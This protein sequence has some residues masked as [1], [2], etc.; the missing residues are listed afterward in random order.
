MPF[1]SIVAG[2]DA[3]NLRAS[4]SAL[5]AYLLVTNKVIVWQAEAN[6]AKSD[7]NWGTLAWTTTASGAYTDCRA[8]M[9]VFISS[10]TDLTNPIVQ[11]RLR[12]TPT[13]TH[14]AIGES[15]QNVT[16]GD[17]ITV[18]DNFPLIEKKSRIESGSR[19]KDYDL[20]YKAPPVRISDIKP[21]YADLSG[22]ST[23]TWSLAPTVTVTADGDAVSTYLWDV[24]DGTITIG[25]TATKDITVEFPNS[26]KMRWIHLTVVTT[27]GTSMTFHIQVFTVDKHADLNTVVK[28]DYGPI[29]ISGSVDG[30]WSGEITP[31][32][33]FAVADVLDGNRVTVVGE[34]AYDLDG[35]PVT[36]AIQDNI[37]LTGYLQIENNNQTIDSDAGALEDVSL[38]IVGM[39]EALANV[40]ANRQ[41]IADVASPLEW[42]DITSP[43]PL[44][45]L[46]SHFAYDST[47]LSLMPLEADDFSDY[48]FDGEALFIKDQD[49]KNNAKFL[50]EPVNAELV[51][52]ADGTLGFYRNVNFQSTA[53]RAARDT[54]FD[55]DDDEADYLALESLTKEHR[56]NFGQAELTGAVYNTTALAVSNTFTGQ[57]PS[58]SFGSGFETARLEGQILIAD[59]TDTAAMAEISQR[60]ANLLAFVN[61]KWELTASL[62]ETFAF[63]QPSLHQWH[64]HT[65]SALTNVRQRGSS[66]SIRWFLHTID[67]DID[68]TTDELSSVS[69]TW[70]IETTSTGAGIKVRKVPI[71]GEFEYDMPVDSAFDQ[72]PDDFT[73]MSPLDDIDPSFGLG[74]GLEAYNPTEPYPPGYDQTPPAN[75]EVLDVSM[76]TGAAKS[77]SRLTVSGQQYLIRVE[78]MGQI[79]EATAPYTDTFDFTVDDQGWEKMPLDPGDQRGTYVAATG[80]TYSNLGIRIFYEFGAA[81]NV[82]KLVAVYTAPGAGTSRAFAVGWGQ[83]PVDPYDNADTPNWSSL[84][85]PFDAPGTDIEHSWLGSSITAERVWVYTSANSQTMTLTEVRV[86]GAATGLDQFGDAFYQWD[87]DT[88]PALYAAGKGLRVNGALPTGFGPYNESHIYEFYHTGDGFDIDF[89]WL[90]PDADYSDN[91][92]QNIRITVIGQNMGT[93]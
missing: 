61:P 31:W 35:T 57:A 65:F 50:G 9:E 79:T 2:G 22:A 49:I 82:N 91:A 54:I 21:T 89:Q 30:G 69:A 73:A 45:V 47:A 83:N 62:P 34:Y 78:G 17:V 56:N 66:D 32:D 18:L 27:A 41:N 44:K 14:I 59:S 70:H 88:D 93:Y 92:N 40:R 53:E 12:S 7:E 75:G 87:E 10:T 63:L 6:E 80:W 86:S 36:D 64:T 68:N 37:L 13:A 60:V 58:I 20:A 84:W 81:K 85:H 55:F 3:N 38:T 33:N 29:S 74:S 72:F 25:T 71:T 19:F 51:S 76:K 8:D 15:G 90:D 4:H 5:E 1:N 48:T 24:D 28:L 52:A 11:D 42:G 46:V 43:D 16:S 67:I 26:K 23:V 39:G 77:T